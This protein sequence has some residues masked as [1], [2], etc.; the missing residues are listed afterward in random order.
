MC[1]NFIL[2]YVSLYILALVIARNVGLST[3]TT[4]RLVEIAFSI[5]F[6]AGN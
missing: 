4:L 3:K 6:N 1:I 5:A 2:T